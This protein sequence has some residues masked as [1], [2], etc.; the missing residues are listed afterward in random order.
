ML[1]CD[2]PGATQLS[3]LEEANKEAS[4]TGRVLTPGRCF[5][6]QT[7]IRNRHTTDENGQTGWS[8]TT[9][10]TRFKEPRSSLWKI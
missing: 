3:S 7:F 8:K 10:E 5:V 6:G 4:C 1:I 2:Q 9:D